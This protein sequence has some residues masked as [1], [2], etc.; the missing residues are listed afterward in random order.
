MLQEWTYVKPYIH[1]SS[2]FWER[3]VERLCQHFVVAHG[4]AF[5]EGRQP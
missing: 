4:G 1:D 2:K 5:I 3:R